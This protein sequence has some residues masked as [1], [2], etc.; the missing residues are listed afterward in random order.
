MSE[1]LSYFDLTAGLAARRIAGPTIPERPPILPQ[2]LALGAGV[3]IAPLVHQLARAETI[4]PS[5]AIDLPLLV[6]LIAAILVFPPAYR[7][8]FDPERPLLAQLAA[9][10]LWGIGWQSLLG[11]AAG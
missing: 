10:F 3:A 6:G 1:L 5:A 2:Y 11:A 7:N 8:A 9:I 4:D